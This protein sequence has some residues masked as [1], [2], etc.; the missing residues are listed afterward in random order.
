MVCRCA[1]LGMGGMTPAAHNLGGD[2]REKLPIC[3]RLR[4]AAYGSE[5]C[6]IIE[7]AADTIEALVE[8]LAKAE[9][10]MSAARTEINRLRADA[11][12]PAREPAALNVAIYDA[13]AA[14]SRAR[15]GGQP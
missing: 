13:K 7:E 5:D 11:N 3:E 14:L 10:M 4:C 1:Y 2:T 6:D 15:N 12:L 8:A 9:A